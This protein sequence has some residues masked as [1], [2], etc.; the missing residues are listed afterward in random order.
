MKDNKITVYDQSGEKKEF[1]ILFTYDDEDSSSH[2]VFYYDENDEEQVFVSK[3]DE[4]G[5]LYPIEDP[6]EWDKTEEILD[7]YLANDAVGGESCGGE[8]CE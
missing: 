5:H 6:K 3:Y 2:Y 1:E 7:S 4:E 8:D